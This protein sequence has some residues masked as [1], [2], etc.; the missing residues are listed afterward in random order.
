MSFYFRKLE[1]KDW[2]VYGGK[3]AIE[4]TPFE[5]GKNL[6]AI[7]G[8]NG[9]GKTSVLKALQFVFHGGYGREDLLEAWH[10]SAQSNGEGELEVALEFTHQGRTYKI[11]RRAEF[12]PW[13]DGTTAVSPSVHLWLDG[14]EEQDQVEDK[15]Q[16]LIPKGSQQFV[17]FDGAEITR[18]AQ[19]QHEKGVRDAIEQI[20]GIPAVRNLRYDLRRLIENLEKEQTEIV[21][22]EKQNQALLAELEALENEEQS[23]QNRLQQLTEKRNSIKRALAELRQEATQIQA[24]ETERQMLKEKQSRLADLE[25]MRA[26][27]EEAIAALL[28]NSPLHMLT[29]ILVNLIED[30]KAKQGSAA[31]PEV[32]RQAKIIL[33]SLL[34]DIRKD[35]GDDLNDCVA[36]NIRQKLYGINHALSRVKEREPGLLS[37]RDFVELSSLLKQSRSTPRNGAELVDQKAK[38]NDSI[39][40]VETDIRRLREK[41]E[42][43]DMVQVQENFQ[44]QKDYERRYENIVQ[45]IRELENNLSTVQNDVAEKHRKLDQIATDTDRGRGVTATLSTARQLYK[46]VD[47]MV[48]E[49]VQGRRE[50]IQRRATE[51]FTNITNKPVE[52]AGVRVRDDY[53]LEVYRRDGS[54]VEN[55][56]LS[57]GEKEVLAYSF[58][59]AL[60]LTSPDPAPFVMDTPFGH[61]DSTHRDRLL[62]SLPRLEVQ[63]FLLATDRDLPPEERDKFQY[64]IAE[65]YEIERDQ[66]RA[67]SMLKEA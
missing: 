63:V 56:Q 23:Y 14:D 19:K 39:M 24:I 22:V 46:A 1:L 7:H 25:S 40:A 2:L 28:A 66:Q 41:L 62:Q 30:Y 59:T 65:E 45:D 3:Q 37:Q 50:E 13:G 15:I 54:V 6:I 12:R 8:K 55:Q 48:D 51:I 16:Q 36:N 43:H 33:Q 17:F 21:G 58:I 57:A 4:F 11:V 61:L 53:T 27:K 47:E 67:Q 52:Y 60:N 26:E 44:Q 31:D 29:D 32:L 64:A 20:L 49:L 35:C 10:D 38:N 34:R 42:G 5:K 9:F 18:Y